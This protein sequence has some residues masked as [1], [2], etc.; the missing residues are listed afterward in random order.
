MVGLAA[1]TENGAH[2]GVV[3]DDSYHNVARC[4]DL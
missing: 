4:G 1:K 2:R 3:G